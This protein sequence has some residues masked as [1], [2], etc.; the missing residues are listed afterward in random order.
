MAEEK[1]ELALAMIKFT[2]ESTRRV[3]NSLQSVGGNRKTLPNGE[4]LT[5]REIEL[6][7]YLA[8]GFKTKQMA[9]EL[10]LSES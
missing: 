2:Q 9:C 6:L 1:Y 5:G 7:R 10:A 8:K 4:A 3:L